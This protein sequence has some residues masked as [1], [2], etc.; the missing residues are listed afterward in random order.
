MSVTRERFEQGMTYDEYKAQMTRNQERFATNEQQL[1]L[2]PADVAAFKNLPQPLNVLVIAED[3]CGDVINNLPIL[4]RI[5]AESGK[6]NL[7]VFLRDQNLD[8][9]DQ[10]LKEGKFR[11]IPVFVF[12]DDQFREIGRF[13]ERPASVTERN[14][15]YRQ[16]MYA[17]HPEFGSPDASISELPEEIRTALSEATATWREESRPLNNQDVVRSLREI[18]EKVPA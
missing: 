1:A 6:L 14:D 16:K 4:G 10:Y 12:F 15:Q 17:D 2:D 3:W 9:I 13:I 8:L 5:A 18:V 11:S 7:R